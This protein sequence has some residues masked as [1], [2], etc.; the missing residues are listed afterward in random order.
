[1][2]IQEISAA[3]KPD[4]QAGTYKDGELSSSSGAEI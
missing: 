3:E 2:D 4:S 1:M